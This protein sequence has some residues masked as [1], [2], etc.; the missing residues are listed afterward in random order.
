M[1]GR[2][3]VS[4][5]TC[6][7]PVALASLF[8]WLFFSHGMLLEPYWKPCDHICVDLS[9]D[10]RFCIGILHSMAQLP[11]CLWPLRI[12]AVTPSPPWLFPGHGAHEWWSWSPNPGPLVATV[13]GVPFAARRP[14]LLAVTS[15]SSPCHCLTRPPSGSCCCLCP[16]PP[17]VLSWPPLSFLS[18]LLSLSVS[19]FFPILSVS[20]C[21]FCLCPVSLTGPICLISVSK[22]TCPE[23]EIV[24]WTVPQG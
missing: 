9:V 15:R 8:K 11:R 18:L 23:P 21:S 17:V 14:S 3:P 6:G 16:Q 5:F 1:W 22:Q 4:F 20:H 12:A 13:G 19:L 10:L 7:Y 2:G 24:E